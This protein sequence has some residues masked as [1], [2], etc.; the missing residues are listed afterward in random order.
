MNQE[1][2]HRGDGRVR[3]GARWVVEL[4]HIV[5]GAR[6]SI[7]GQIF[8]LLKRHEFRRRDETVGEIF[9]W[10]A[11]CADCGRSFITSSSSSGATPTR[12]CR[13]HRSAGKAVAGNHKRMTVT[14]LPPIEK[15]GAGT[16]PATGPTSA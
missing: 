3:Q 6:M 10:Q 9:A 2:L 14:W 4:A 13:E 12:R 7:D 16:T 5:P 11:P 15:A 8:T 1:I